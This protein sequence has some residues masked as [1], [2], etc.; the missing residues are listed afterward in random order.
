MCSGDGGSSSVANSIRDRISYSGGDAL[1]GRKDQ[2][3]H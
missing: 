3:Y 1:S 2:A